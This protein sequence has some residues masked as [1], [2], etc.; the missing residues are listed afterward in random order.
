MSYSALELVC[1]CAV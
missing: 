1:L